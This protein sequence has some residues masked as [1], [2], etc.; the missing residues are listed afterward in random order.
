MPSA[1]LRSYWGLPEVGD[2]RLIWTRDE[3]VKPFEKN[4]K[5]DASFGGR[6]ILQVKKKN[7]SKADSLCYTSPDA[8]GW[9][10][11]VIDVYWLAAF[12]K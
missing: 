1:N 9:G 3:N 12:R 6:L 2:R 5:G 11:F 10:G 7:G 8:D 4:R